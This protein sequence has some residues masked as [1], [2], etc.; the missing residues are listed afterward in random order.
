MIGC[1]SYNDRLQAGSVNSAALGARQSKVWSM[2]LSFQLPAFIL[3]LHHVLLALS[4][5]VFLPACVTRD[6][7]VGPKPA[8]VDRVNGAVNV[9]QPEVVSLAGWQAET[10]ALPPGF[11]PE[12]PTGTES[13]RFS[14]GWRNPN[15][16]DF[17]SY[18]FVMWINEPMPDAARIDDLLEKY[19]NGL[20]TSFAAGKEMDIS[21]TPARVDVVRSGA[22]RYEAR[23]HLVDAF[24]T[25][26][27]ID[28]SVLVDTVAEADARTI[29][30]IQVSP[31]PKE[32]A[33]WRSLNE[34]I[35]S[36]RSHDAATHVKPNELAPASKEDS[37]R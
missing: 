32:H 29:L 2:A 23:M 36:I 17:W 8:L 34:A 9:R 3:R 16:E 12:L 20:M 4:A 26:E 10:F 15:A 19:Y 37:S 14:P 28:L 18:A 5:V 21:G 30:H 22:H 25:F 31:Q 24:A 1:R 13:L 27:P 6:S 7:T 11:A 35:A 33:I